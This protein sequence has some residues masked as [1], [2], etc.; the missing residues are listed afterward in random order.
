[1]KYDEYEMPDDYKRSLK[2]YT[3]M[4]NEREHFA[5]IIPTLPDKE[6][7]EAVPILKEFDKNL[8]TVEQSL[9][10]QFDQFQTQE[11]NI[12]EKREDR[13]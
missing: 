1:M 5:K 12:D 13:W 3:E 2:Q 8:D 4:L 11:R 9:P 10:E 6:R 7:R